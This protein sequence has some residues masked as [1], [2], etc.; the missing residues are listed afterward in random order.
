MSASCSSSIAQYAHQHSVWRANGRVVYLCSASAAFGAFLHS[1]ETAARAAQ[2]LERAI[3]LDGCSDAHAAAHLQRALPMFFRGDGLDWSGAGLDRS[4]G[5]SVDLPA[6]KF[7]TDAGA[8][9]N[10]TH[11]MG[12]HVGSRPVRIHTDEH[13]HIVELSEHAELLSWHCFLR[14]LL[15]PRPALLALMPPALLDGSGG[16]RAFS[17]LHVRLGDGSMSPPGAARARSTWL[18]GRPPTIWHWHDEQ[19]LLDPGFQRGDDGASGMLRCFASAMP[20]PHVVVSDTR[21][22]LAAAERRGLVTT[23][24][25]GVP[26]NLGMQL[27]HT[28]GDL[29]K[30]FLDWW[31]LANAHAAASAGFKDTHHSV[32]FTSQFIWTARSWHTENSAAHPPYRLGCEQRDKEESGGDGRREALKRRYGVIFDPAHTR[33][34]SCTAGCTHAPPHRGA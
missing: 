15:A 13:S 30:L 33:T 5:V 22:V 32:P 3:L 18:V 25:V 7:L 21:A 4:R 23:S 17:A 10:R 9:F 26:V 2:L 6:T 16:V 34:L 14:A 31:L 11:A 12:V 20:A 28:A 27:N 24:A 1:L 19:R 8:H 29:R